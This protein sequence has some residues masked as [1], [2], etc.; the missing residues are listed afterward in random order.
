M[1]AGIA[2]SG[3][4]ETLT[5]L[6]GSASQTLGRMP[7]S[8]AGGVAPERVVGLL[9]HLGGL[10]GERRE[11]TALEGIGLLDASSLQT[12]SG[13]ERKRPRR[14]SQEDLEWLTG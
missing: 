1:F 2:I 4:R 10:E 6:E 8:G 7:D 12:L 5:A 13:S 14:L 9:L 3:I 11:R